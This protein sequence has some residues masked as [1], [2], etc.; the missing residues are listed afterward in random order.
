[1]KVVLQLVKQASVKVKDRLISEIGKGYLL[2]CGFEEGDDEKTLSQMA[3]KVVNLRIFPDEN[4]KTNLSLAQVGGSILAVSQFTLLADCSHGN[5]PSFTKAMGRM[6]AKGV[7]EAFLEELRK[8]GAEVQPGSYGD[9]MAV[10]LINDG[11]FTLYLD[12][13]ELF[14]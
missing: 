13:K 9:D 7:Y 5:R 4:G 1:M 11:P 8:L 12:S 10:S 2:L 3:H 6:E 14:R